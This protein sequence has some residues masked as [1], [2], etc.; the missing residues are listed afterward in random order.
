[1]IRSLKIF[2][3]VILIAVSVLSCKKTKDYPIEPVIGFKELKKFTDATTSIDTGLVLTF[4]FTDGDGDLGYRSGDTLPPFN[5]SGEYYSNLIL[6]FYYMDNGT[7]TELISSAGPPPYRIPA[8]ESNEHSKATAGDLIV[9]IEL[10]GLGDIIPEDTFRFEIYVT[11][12]AL[13]KS[14]T[15]TTSEIFLHL[16]N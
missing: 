9:D 10:A 3:A 5:S 7:F 13:H 12:R 15:I 16:K 8:I 14:N 4:S 2:T 1:M 6:K 11:D